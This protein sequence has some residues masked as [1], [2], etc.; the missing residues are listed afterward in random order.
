MAI[1]TIFT[2][3]C[4]YCFTGGDFR[5]MT[6]YKDGRFLCRDCAHTVR[7]G[8]PEYRCTCRNCLKMLKL[9]K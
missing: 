4:P 3:R 8:V 5:V 6:A 7:P 9:T 2:V 1:D